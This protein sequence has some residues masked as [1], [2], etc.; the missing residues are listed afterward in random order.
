MSELAGPQRS[1][2]CLRHSSGAGLLLVVPT[3]RGDDGVDG[4]TASYLLSV[5]LS[6]LNKEEEEKARKERKAQEAK[7]E[8]KMLEPAARQRA[9]T[10]ELDTLLLVPFERRTDQEMARVSELRMLLDCL[11]R[12]HAALLN[13]SKKRKSK[14]KRRKRTRCSVSSSTGSRRTCSRSTCC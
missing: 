12:N 5:T 11:S 7:Y 14:K 2:R 4:T 3:L 13:A 10:L 8:D 9:V 1:D 6:E